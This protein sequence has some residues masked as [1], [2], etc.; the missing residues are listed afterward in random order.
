MNSVDI[1]LYIEEDRLDPLSQDDVT[2]F[3]ALLPLRHDPGS[4]PF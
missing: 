2:P 1:P 4:N 3:T